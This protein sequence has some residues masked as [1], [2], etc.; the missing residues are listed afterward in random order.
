M[1]RNLRAEMARNEISIKELAEF[2][3]VRHATI[4]DKINGK[5]RFYYDEAKAIKDKYFPEMPIEYLF[6]SDE[7]TA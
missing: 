2:L 7:Q 4:S 1:Y 6:E 5:Y 3:K